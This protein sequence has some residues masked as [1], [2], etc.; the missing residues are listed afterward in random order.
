[1]GAVKDKLLDTGVRPNVIADCVGVVDG[2]VAS[3]KGMTGLVIKGGYKAFK[4]L[5]PGIVEE[6][7]N[8]LLDDFVAIVDRHY[9]EYLGRTGTI[10]RIRRVDGAARYA[11]RRR[12]VGRDRRRHG[13]DQVHCAQEDI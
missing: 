10:A 11:S 9:D 12:H 3:K 13:S 8:H 6:A 1:M 2:E 7:V 4:A 5:K